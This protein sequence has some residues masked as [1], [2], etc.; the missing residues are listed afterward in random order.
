MHGLQLRAIPR[1]HRRTMPELT[2]D[3]TRDNQPSAKE[4]DAD[5][6]G[7]PTGNAAQMLAFIPGRPSTAG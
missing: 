1:R 5:G 3:P 6:H 4:Q 2:L 7:F